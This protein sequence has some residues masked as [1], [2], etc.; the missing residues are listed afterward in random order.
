VRSV[1]FASA[2]AMATINPFELLG[3]VDNDDP[4]QLLAA[5]AVTKQKAEGKKA[6][7]PT[8]GKGA[9]PVPAKLPTKPAPPSQAGEF[10][11]GFHEYWILVLGCMLLV[12]LLP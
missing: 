11:V 7:A 10:V 6:A 5:A 3:A 2:V 12:L 4:A 8:A 9:Q 1:A